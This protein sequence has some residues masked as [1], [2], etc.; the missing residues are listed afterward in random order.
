MPRRKA[1]RQTKRHTDTSALTRRNTG[2]NR[3][4]GRTNRGDAELAGT[5]FSLF[6]REV[7]TSYSCAMSS[8][9]RPDASRRRR[10]ATLLGLAGMLTLSGAS[11][12]A[13]VDWFE[14][15]LQKTLR[16]CSPWELPLNP[17]AAPNPLPDASAISPEATPE[18]TL[19]LEVP[20]GT[21]SG[22]KR[23]RDAEER[24]K[25]EIRSVDDFEDPWLGRNTVDVADGAEV[26][27]TGDQLE[28]HPA[29]SYE[30]DVDL[31]DPWAN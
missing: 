4:T 22:G 25:L 27:G 14:T 16:L 9:L 1:N 6:A 13:D 3:N 10:I 23:A 29:E 11:A 24:V 8:P 7:A 15:A 19:V 30:R 28:G 17:E 20:W 31:I 26:T 21:N 12:Q 2:R 5:L 18:S